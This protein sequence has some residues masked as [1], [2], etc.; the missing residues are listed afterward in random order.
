[1]QGSPEATELK[2]TRKVQTEFLE[3]K[4]QKVKVHGHAARC[5]IATTVFNA[6]STVALG[7][8]A[9]SCVATFTERN[10]ASEMRDL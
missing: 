7:A 4:Q 6:L 9:V 1:L 8:V 3:L 10:I 5:G 2:N